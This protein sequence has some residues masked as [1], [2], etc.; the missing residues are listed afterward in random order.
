MIHAS[1]PARTRRAQYLFDTRNTYA[2]LGTTIGVNAR[3]EQT[4]NYYYIAELADPV[5][6]ALGSRVD[7]AVKQLYCDI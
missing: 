2:P 5:R 1:P 3:A 6:G 4:P 7:P